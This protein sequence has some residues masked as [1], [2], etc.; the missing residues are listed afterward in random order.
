MQGYVYIF[1]LLICS[2]YL[3]KL[4]GLNIPGSIV[5]L[6]IFF[7]FFTI[8]KSV[9]SDID[10]SAK[11]LLKYLPLFLVPIGVGIKELFVEFDSKLIAMI[12]AS[13]LSL[14][15]AVFITVFT[16]WITKFFIEK[17]SNKNILNSDD[18][19]EDL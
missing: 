19:K 11:V 7:I 5:G 13:L 4:L 17:F 18:I 9:P 6:F 1:A 10:S 12:I 3:V 14:V 8:K 16:I 15:L 2:E